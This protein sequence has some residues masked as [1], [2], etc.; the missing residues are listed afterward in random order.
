MVGVPLRLN[1]HAHTIALDG[2]YP[3]GDSTGELNFLPLTEPSPADVQELAE[4]SAARIERMERKASPSRA[5][6]LSRQ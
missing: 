5:W 2:V 4:R 3:Q 6:R 1:V